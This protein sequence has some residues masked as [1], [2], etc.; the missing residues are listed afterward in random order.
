MEKMKMFLKKSA[1]L[2]C[3]LMA[4]PMAA[5][6]QETTNDSTATM[7]DTLV[8][9]VDFSS[10]ITGIGS[11]AAGLMGVYLAVLAFRFIRGMVSRG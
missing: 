3:A 10:V 4:A 6:A 11:I 5:M 7:I 2:C 8:A 9:K 1:V